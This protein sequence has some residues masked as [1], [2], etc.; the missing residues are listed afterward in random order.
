VDD[1][2]TNR[3]ILRRQVESWGMQADEYEHARDAL[4]RLRG[5]GAY[6]LAI[7]DIQMPDMDGVTLAQEI[8]HLESAG[9]MPL[10]ALSSL[11]RREANAEAANFA[12]FLT[13]PIKQSQ[14]YDVLIDVF[15]GQGAAI[16]ATATPV[17]HFDTTMGERLP[18]RILLA[19]D[20][21]VNQRLMI[22]MLGRMGYRADVANNG[23]E[24]LAALERQ[25][26][27]LVLMDIQM[28]EMDGLEASRQ[29]RQRL[30]EDRQPRIVA[31]TANAM[32]EDRE[33]CRQAGMD[34]YL[35]KPVQVKELHAALLRCADWRQQ[36]EPAPPTAKASAAAAP[37]AVEVLD[38]DTLESLRQMGAMTGTNVVLDLLTL[39]RSEAPPLVEKL[40]TAVAAA[41]AEQ[42]KA[43]AHSLKGAAANLGAK[44]L[45]AVCLELEK[46]GRAATV[47][48]AAERLPDVEKQLELVCAALEAEGKKTP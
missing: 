22:A 31:L 23:L 9:G 46:L 21:A 6:D 1:N 35:S 41:D 45:A 20:L 44:A 10:V 43:A 30:S 13:K 19:E 34:D 16:R 42:L 47:Q 5:D 39:F 17:F 29:V 38:A 32:V 24:V 7:L 26:Y 27:D 8:R 28:P 25:P 36:R 11:G 14:L 2:A 4:E 33:A 3:Q 18:L 15:A 48:G 37:A 40:K 12:A